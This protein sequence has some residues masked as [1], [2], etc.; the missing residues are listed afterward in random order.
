MMVA[1]LSLLLLVLRGLSDL[2]SAQLMVSVPFSTDP[3]LVVRTDAVDLGTLALSGGPFVSTRNSSS[4]VFRHCAE[5]TSVTGIVY[6]MPYH[7]RH[8][9]RIDANGGLAEEFGPDLG[10]FTNM[11]SAFGAYAGLG[12]VEA[13]LDGKVYFVPMFGDQIVVVDPSDEDSVTFVNIDTERRFRQPCD[14]TLYGDPAKC[15]VDLVLGKLAGYLSLCQVPLEADHG[16]AGKLY[17]PAG[18]AGSFE[19]EAAY[20][21]KID[22][23]TQTAVELRD[24][25]FTRGLERHAQWLVGDVLSG[26][27]ASC[28]YSAISGKIYS[29][30]SFGDDTSNLP[31]MILDPRDDSVVTIDTGLST[32]SFVSNKNAVLWSN[33]AYTQITVGPNGKLYSAPYSVLENVILVIDPSD[34][35]FA[36]IGP[37]LYSEPSGAPFTNRIG[38]LQSYRQYWTCALS[39]A[40]MDA[41]YCPPDEASRYLKINTTDHT[42][43][44]DFLDANFTTEFQPGV[45]GNFESATVAPNGVIISHPYFSRVA[46]WM[47]PA[48]ETYG[49]LGPWTHPNPT[50]AHASDLKYV[51]TFCQTDTDCRHDS[52]CSMTDGDSSSTN[53]RRRRLNFGFFTSGL[54]QPPDELPN[55]AAYRESISFGLVDMA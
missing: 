28:A 50:H 4:R 10:S 52:T 37:L 53:R 54:C 36:T 7:G 17:A 48:T 20:Y 12:A 35:S 27:A 32:G 38:G 24:Y 49:V 41:I 16:N 39:L 8:L 40:T 21:L 19:G 6:C 42:F 47:D 22:P 23:L 45:G 14:L 55:F 15:P 3:A 33:G 31:I 5:A 44:Q 30:P 29:P 46:I 13:L 1:S 2:S 26:A 9:L 11:D 18:Q 25:P 43:S 34:D 51:P